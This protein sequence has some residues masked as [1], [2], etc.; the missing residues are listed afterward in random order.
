MGMGWIQHQIW[1]P[2]KLRY[3]AH[4]PPSGT[5]AGKKKDVADKRRLHMR[6]YAIAINNYLETLTIMCFWRKEAVETERQTRRRR[7]VTDVVISHSVTDVW[8]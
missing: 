2:E 6:S 7:P 4:P 8:R 5:A 3:T 1:R